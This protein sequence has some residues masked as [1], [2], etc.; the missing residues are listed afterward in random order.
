MISAA[1]D[2]LLTTLAIILILYSHKRW[3]YTDSYVC[4]AVPDTDSCDEWHV[5]EFKTYDINPL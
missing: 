2:V 5:T 3:Y 1:L 4:V